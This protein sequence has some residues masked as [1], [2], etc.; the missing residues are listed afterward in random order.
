MPKFM[1]KPRDPGLSYIQLESVLGI[2]FYNRNLGNLSPSDA[3]RIFIGK[4]VFF[5]YIEIVT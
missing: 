5:V 1:A 2:R 4:I 3:Y